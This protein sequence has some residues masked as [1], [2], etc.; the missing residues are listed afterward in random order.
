MTEI[1]SLRQS[2]ISWYRANHRDLPWRKT[3]NPYYIWVSEVMLQQTQVK[4]VLPY[5][6]LFLKRFAS[7]NGWPE[8]IC[9]MF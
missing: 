5:Y 2:L 8:P 6:R 7:L 3:S 1:Q 9:R 4:T